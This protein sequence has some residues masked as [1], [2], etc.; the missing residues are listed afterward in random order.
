M[1]VLPVLRHLGVNLEGKVSGNLIAINATTVATK[2]QTI[3]HALNVDD[4]VTDRQIDRQGNS[5]QRKL[6]HTRDCVKHT[7]NASGKATNTQNGKTQEVSRQRLLNLSAK[8]YKLTERL[9]Y[10]I[11]NG[12]FSC[13]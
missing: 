2:T 3:R 6:K 10:A 12:L 7:G 4:K 11:L 8:S 1:N 9:K 5:Q 13:K